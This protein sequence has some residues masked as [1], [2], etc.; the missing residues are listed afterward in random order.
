M[1]TKSEN[2]LTLQD[3]LVVTQIFTK[4]YYQAY[5]NGITY[6]AHLILRIFKDLGVLDI[7]GR[8]YVSSSEIIR[9]FNFAPETKYALEWILSFLNQSGYL[10]KS[11][12]K[13][14]YDKVEDIDLS[15]LLKDTLDIDKGILPSARLMEYVIS[16]YP[17]FLKGLKKGLEIL[18][19]DEKSGLWNNYFSNENSGYRVH[20][21]LGAFAVLKWGLKK[22]GI[23]FLEVGAGTGSAT[24]ALIGHLKQ[25]GILAQINEYIFS[26]VS[27]V[28]LR[29]GNR[30]IMNI[31]GDDFNYSLKRLDFNKSIIQQGITEDSI[32]VVY[33]VN[34]LHVAKNLADSLRNIYKVIKPGGALILSECLRP[35]THYLLC[36]EIIFNLLENYVNVDLDNDLRPVPG[37]LDYGHW[38]KNLEA[39]GF[40]NIEY[41]FNTDGNCPQGLESKVGLLA[42]AIKAEKGEG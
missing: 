6:V 38:E 26:D 7:L 42:I 10:K 33:G 23:R 9:D 11:A 15:A 19:A 13:Y 40:R 5:L 28:F 1:I 8:G 4:E 39:A 3:R 30:A 35:D 37:F 25:K 32:D 17:N 12:D 27:P 20:N 18:F 16:E 34:T 36:Q 24:S 22:D 21:A 41:V 29:I 2:N 31:T 14:R